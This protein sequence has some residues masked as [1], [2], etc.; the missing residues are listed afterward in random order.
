MSAALSQYF[1]SSKNKTKPAQDHASPAGVHGTIS[2]TLKCGGCKVPVSARQH[3]TGEP[4]THRDPP[5]SSSVPLQKPHKDAGFL[6]GTGGCEEP[7]CWF[8]VSVTK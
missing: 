7:G 3:R 2:R 1:D 8:A 4:V 5:P 6:H